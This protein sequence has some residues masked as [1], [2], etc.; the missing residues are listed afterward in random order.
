MSAGRS[1][2]ASRERLLSQ[3]LPADVTALPGKDVEDH[4]AHRRSAAQ[5]ALERR[6]PVGVEQDALPVED[7]R[8]RP[9]GPPPRPGTGP[10]STGTAPR[11]PRRCGCAGRPSRPRGRG[12]VRARRPTSPRSSTPD[13]TAPPPV[14]V[15]RSRASG[16]PRPTGP[17]PSRSQPRHHDGRVAG[18]SPCFPAPTA[19]Q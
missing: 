2:E 3:G 5:G 7:R 16:R 1:R 11:G 14:Q 18:P 10:R 4:E 8:Q 17:R 19:P 12:Q 13:R 6:P 9:A 15:G